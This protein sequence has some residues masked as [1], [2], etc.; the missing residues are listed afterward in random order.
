VKINLTK[1]SKYNLVF[2]LNSH[3][4]IVFNTLYG[5]LTLVDKE[6]GS[7][8]RSGDI[9][10]LASNPVI[11]DEL[12]SVNI[13]LNDDL[14]ENEVFYKFS[15]ESR[16]QSKSIAMFL[17]LTS[18]CNLACKY[19]YQSLRKTI[20][21]SDLTENNWKILRGFLERRAREGYELIAIALYGGEP[22]L[23]PLMA[24]RV[25]REV[26]ELSVR[27]SVQRELMLITNGTIL[28]KEV[29]DVIHGVDAVQ[30][31]IDG[32]REIH[33]KRRPFKNGSGSFDVITSN[34]VKLLDE[35]GK[36]VGVRVNVDEHN[37]DH[38]EELI[39]YLAEI[40][41]QS[42][43]GTIDLSTVH[44]D[45]ANM[46]NPLKKSS[47]MLEYYRNIS[48]RIVDAVEY[49]ARKGFK[50]DKMF[51]KGPCMCK[52]VTGYAV[53]ENLNIYMCPAY[54]YT[55]PVGK[56]A[57]EKLMV[58]DPHRYKPIL[59][60]PECTVNCKY[61][62]ICYG[63]CVYLQYKNIPTCLRV[64]YGDE[65]IEKLLR[66]YI[67]S[68]YKDIIKSEGEKSYAIEKVIR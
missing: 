49:A 56:I 22:L 58:L 8:I 52:Y 19:C 31:T 60:D 62:P 68:N 16:F 59:N 18:K 14:D 25:V 28:N 41:V 17:G 29:E 66:A 3:Y 12:L 2:S 51:V 39:D 33:D 30:V 7:A 23:N 26:E 54:M 65:Y 11:R 35:Y 20:E 36:Y 45:Q 63:G 15:R 6:T 38:V 21:G 61:A 57:T 53:D 5:S 37:V 55:K 48:R 4:D 44:P 42:K 40:G 10:A 67:M 1:L 9:G 50:V 34:L 13:L 27:Y 46:Y 47:S 32:L 24:K 64:I 43:L